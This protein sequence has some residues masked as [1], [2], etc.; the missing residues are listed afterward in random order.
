MDKEVIAVWRSLEMTLHVEEIPRRAAQIITRQNTSFRCPSQSRSLNLEIPIPGKC[1]KLG[2]WPL[3][4]FLIRALVVHKIF[5]H[6]YKE[7]LPLWQQ[8]ILRQDIYLKLMLWKTL[9]Q[10]FTCAYWNIIYKS[11]LIQRLILVSVSWNNFYTDILI[12]NLHL[13]IT[14]S[15]AEV[16]FCFLLMQREELLVL[17][18]TN[19]TTMAQKVSNLSWAAEHYLIPPGNVK[20][21]FCIYPQG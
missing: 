11:C 13:F 18:K 3:S 21:W 5:E 9:A 12:R 8:N 20:V 14:Q 7:G 19:S 16:L 15:S 17:C 10:N 2:E 1:P 4:L 6:G